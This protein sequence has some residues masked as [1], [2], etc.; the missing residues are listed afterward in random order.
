[1]DVQLLKIR[2]QILKTTGNTN[3]HIYYSCK[4]NK[5]DVACSQRKY[6]TKEVRTRIITSDN[7]YF[8]PELINWSPYNLLEEKIRAKILQ[9][10]KE[11]EKLELED[12]VQ[13]KVEE[14]L[15]DKIE[16]EKLKKEQELEE[17]WD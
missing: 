17:F 13:K 12:P 8:I 11:R 14:E 1:M 16:Q 3:V 10:R 7:N 2:I 4:G 6:I 15:E 9:A 5:K